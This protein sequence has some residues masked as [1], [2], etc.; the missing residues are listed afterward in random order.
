MYVLT[1]HLRI[2]SSSTKRRILH[3]PYKRLD[4]IFPSSV[5][6]ALFQV[7]QCWC[8]FPHISTKRP[9]HK[10]AAGGA[11]AGNSVPFFGKHDQKQQ[12]C[13]EDGYSSEC[14]CLFVS[15][16]DYAKTTQPIFHEMLWRGGALL[17]EEPVTFWCRN[18]IFWFFTFLQL[19]HIGS[20]S[21]RTHALSQC[22]FW[23]L[24]SIIFSFQ[25]Y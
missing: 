4:S 22:P 7:K 15:R 8:R 3:F 9:V 5:L 11:T 14:V 20:W 16:Q 19:G 10:S 18:R 25:P 23:F 17:R 12:R 13:K 21:W 2:A 1:F 24:I 6:T